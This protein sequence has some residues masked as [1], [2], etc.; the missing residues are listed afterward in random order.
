MAEKILC[1]V[2]GCGRVVEVGRGG[3][4]GTDP[5]CAMHYARERRNSP[6][7]LEPG[8]LNGAPKPLKLTVYVTGKLG[9]AVSKR[10]K[11]LKLSI[12]QLGERAFQKLLEAEDGD[13]AAK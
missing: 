5:R 10:A 2:A 13:G 3:R 8:K 9:A 12:S 11:K 6:D 4:G 1:G 7:A